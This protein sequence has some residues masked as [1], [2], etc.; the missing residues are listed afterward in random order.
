MQMRWL[1]CPQQSHVL[2]VERRTVAGHSETDRWDGSATPWIDGYPYW[3]ARRRHRGIAASGLDGHLLPNAVPFMDLN[4]VR[5]PERRRVGLVGS[6]SP[7]ALILHLPEIA[8]EPDLDLAAP[9][10]V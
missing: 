10:G 1:E 4:R 6:I 5:Q 8:F 9:G 3:S 7:V 2:V